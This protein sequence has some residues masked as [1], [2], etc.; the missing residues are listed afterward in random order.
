MVAKRVKSSPYSERRATEEEVLSSI[1]H[2]GGTK[3]HSERILSNDEDSEAEHPPDK[4]AVEIVDSIGSTIDAKHSVEMI[5]RHRKE[6]I[7]YMAFGEDSIIQRSKCK[8]SVDEEDL[9][10]R[11]DDI[12][13][14][15]NQSKDT[16]EGPYDEER[17]DV[18]GRIGERSQSNTTTR[19]DTVDSR[20]TDT[21]GD[22]RF[23]NSLDE[24]DFSSD[25]DVRNFSYTH[26]S[27]ERTPRSL[28]RL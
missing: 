26:V 19:A 7:E 9:P 15:F 24:E 14:R 4:Y 16:I 23:M 27:D 6:H 22:S 18:E 11:K 2:N 13:S 28:M 5:A 20:Y 25:D 21:D 17:D 8:S 1:R 10:E 12:S 3:Q